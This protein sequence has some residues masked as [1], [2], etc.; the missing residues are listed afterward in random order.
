MNNLLLFK[1]AVLVGSAQ[2]EAYNEFGSIWFTSES[3]QITLFTTPAEASTSLTWKIKS[4]G[5]INLDTL[6]RYLVL[7]HIIETPIF[8]SDTIMFEIAFTGTNTALTAA[9][10]ELMTIDA[11][12]CTVKNNSMQP[13]YWSQVVEDG[14]YHDVDGVSTYAA[15]LTEN[16]DWT[17]W[18]VDD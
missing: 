9:Q 12:R 10:Q 3:T 17:L 15:D 5:E 16:Q 4:Y 6:D 18:Q 14:Y 11:A 1:A 13:T 7:E 2:A 8:Q